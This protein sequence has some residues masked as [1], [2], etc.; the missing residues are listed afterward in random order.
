[1]YITIISS[2]IGLISIIVMWKIFTKAGRKG[3]ESLIPIYNFIVMMQIAELPMWYLILLFIPFANIYLAFKL[4]IELAHKFG[5]STGFGVACVFF[6][7]ICYPILAFG[8]ATY[9]S[10]KTQTSGPIYTEP[11]LQTY[12]MNNG[13]IEPSPVTQPPMNNQYQQPVMSNPQQPMQQPTYQAPAPVVEQMNTQFQ[14]PVVNEPQPVASDM[15]ELPSINQ[16]I[17]NAQP[18][19]EVNTQQAP[20]QPVISPQ[21]GIDQTQF[22]NPDR[23]SKYCPNCGNEVDIKA[24]T[25][26]M[27]GTKL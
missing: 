26:F 5:K 17:D 6:S 13:P 9:K 20:Q 19:P 10:D 14:Q 12:P 7:F 8:S 4:P 3:W 2:I 24:T 23:T 22:N 1:M 15:Q 25:C 21:Y 27:C 18:I 11:N 16:I